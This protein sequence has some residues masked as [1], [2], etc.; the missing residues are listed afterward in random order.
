[1]LADFCAKYFIWPYISFLSLNGLFSLAGM[2]RTLVAALI[3]AIGIA[4]ATLIFL[5]S[6]A[7]Y[8]KQVL[9]T[10]VFE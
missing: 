2:L 3:A 7:S 1:M 5:N 6:S 9:D 8:G 10:S 4:N